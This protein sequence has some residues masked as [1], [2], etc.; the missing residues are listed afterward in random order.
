MGLSPGGSPIRLSG[1]GGDAFCETVCGGELPGEN[2]K[3][4]WQ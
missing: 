4:K 1:S 2:Q 3:L